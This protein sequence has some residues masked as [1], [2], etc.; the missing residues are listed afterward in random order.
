[1]RMIAKK[2]KFQMLRFFPHNFF[3]NFLCLTLSFCMSSTIIYKSSWDFN[4]MDKNIAV[5]AHRLSGDITDNWFP[6]T[7]GQNSGTFGAALTGALWVCGN[8][9]E[10][11]TFSGFRSQS[12]WN[13]WPGNSES[14]EIIDCDSPG[15]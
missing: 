4:K 7:S 6:S 13:L 15:Q 5:I 3:S 14:I 8:L 12:I 9:F 10:T 1:M 2:F 11:L